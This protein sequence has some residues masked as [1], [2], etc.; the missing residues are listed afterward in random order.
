M[1]VHSGDFIILSHGM[2]TPESRLII[3]IP[4][5][6]SLPTKSKITLIKSGEPTSRVKTSGTNSDI[7]TKVKKM[8]ASTGNIDLK[9]VTNLIKY[10][11]ITEIHLIILTHL[12]Y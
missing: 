1:G 7:P 11:K 5:M 3:K 4:K 2:F 6:S 10:T 12:F 9:Y 8:V